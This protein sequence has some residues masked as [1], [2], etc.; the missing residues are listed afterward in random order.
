MTVL[1][2]RSM[3]IGVTVII[4]IADI[5]PIIIVTSL[6]FTRCIDKSVV[7]MKVTDLRGYRSPRNTLYLTIAVMIRRHHI[8]LP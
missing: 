6:L 4:V 7:L 2:L 3:C 8:C 1:S 5:V